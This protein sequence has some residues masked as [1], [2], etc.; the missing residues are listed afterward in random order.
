VFDC[1]EFLPS[2]GASGGILIAWKDS[3]FRGNLLFTNDFALSIEFT[4]LHNNETW[5][6][7]NVYGPYTPDRKRFLW[8]G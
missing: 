2:I 8:T 7:T 3:L 1:F 5:I 4:S 6:L